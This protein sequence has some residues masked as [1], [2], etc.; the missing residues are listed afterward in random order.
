M[1]PIPIIGLVNQD[2]LYSY[3]LNHL[4]NIFT[5]F[6]LSVETQSQY[7]FIGAILV[8]GSRLQN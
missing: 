1:P 8:V 3:T 6:L 7:W 4:K 5:H 2:W